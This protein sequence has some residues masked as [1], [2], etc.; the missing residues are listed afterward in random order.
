M[1]VQSAIQSLGRRPIRMARHADADG[2][3]VSVI[4]FSKCTDILICGA[5]WRAG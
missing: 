1:Q 3:P 2:K 4:V 5:C